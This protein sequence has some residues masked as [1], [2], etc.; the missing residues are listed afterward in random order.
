ME[1]KILTHLI[2]SRPHTNEFIDQW[3]KVYAEF[4]AERCEKCVSLRGVDIS[5]MGLYVNRYTSC[6]NLMVES[7]E[8]HICNF[9]P[10]IIG[11]ELDRLTREVFENKRLGSVFMFNNFWV[12]SCFLSTNPKLCHVYKNCS[13]S[14][15]VVRSYF[16][17]SKNRGHMFF[18][19][20]DKLF[21]RDRYRREYLVFAPPSTIDRGPEN[22]LDVLIKDI[23]FTSVETSTFL[24]YIYRFMKTVNLA[25]RNIDHISNKYI[26]NTPHLYMVLLRSLQISLETIFQNVND[27]D[28]RVRSSEEIITKF[29]NYA[30]KAN[31]LN[32]MSRR[33]NVKYETGEVM[34]L[35]LKNQ[36]KFK[37]FNHTQM[38][39][40]KNSEFTEFKSS[41]YYF[42]AIDV[43]HDMTNV[44]QQFY[45]GKIHDDSEFD[46]EIVKR[47]KIVNLNAVKCL[48]MPLDFIRFFSFFNVG[49]ISSAGRFMNRTCISRETF[50]VNIQR[51]V[52]QLVKTLLEHYRDQRIAD[53]ENLTVIYINE[54][55]IYF[56]QLEDPIHFFLLVKILVPRA[57]MTFGEFTEKNERYINI[58]I[59]NGIPLIPLTV[60]YKD[61]NAQISPDIAVFCKKC[62]TYRIR[63]SLNYLASRVNTS[64]L[65]DNNFCLR[66]ILI[67]SDELEFLFPTDKPNPYFYE[68]A[69]HGALTITNDHR[70]TEISKMMV[71]INAYKRKIQLINILE[72]PRDAFEQARN[73][74]RNLK[75]T[76]LAFEKNKLQNGCVK[77]FYTFGDYNFL[78]CEDGYVY[79][80][81]YAPNC[82]TFF[83]KKLIYECTKGSNLYF[84]NIFSLHYLDGYGVRIYIGVIYSYDPI[85]FRQNGNYNFFVEEQIEFSRKNAIRLY[86]MYFQWT[87]SF[88]NTELS[89]TVFLPRLTERRFRD[90]SGIKSIS[91]GGVFDFSNSQEH[92]DF[93][94]EYKI[95]YERTQPI[96][97]IS[98]QI[99]KQYFQI[100]IETNSVRQTLKIQ[101]S[102][103]QKGLAQYEDLSR[104]TSEHG[105]PVH[106]ITSIYS[107]LGRSAFGQFRRFSRNAVK[108]FDKLTGEFVGYGAY[109]YFFF[110]NDSAHNNFI[111]N[112]KRGGD[113]PM[114]L[115]RLTYESFLENDMSSAAYV[116]ASEFEPSNSNPY[117]GVSRGI[118]GALNCYALYGKSVTFQRSHGL[119]Y[120]RKHALDKRILQYLENNVQCK[121][122]RKI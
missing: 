74:D 16:Y 1:N 96:N 23:T 42:R 6:V 57:I 31:L 80:K 5:S 34:K 40:P 82:F 45:C 25:E 102:Y 86:F 120:L 50:F 118:I 81:T 64:D 117:S 99:S 17:D 46:F 72:N 119:T 15:S 9:L 10:I 18:L 101:N 70:F 106:L 100:L 36:I 19:H 30:H 48:M 115:C 121:R 77:L 7:N 12:F 85:Y 78:N 90:S 51:T 83:S 20:K 4:K 109:D 27:H 88:L 68:I 67:S 53:S 112:V 66:H 61:D 113:N 92:E 76:I 59:L 65:P 43:I 3:N 52:E 93:I 55:P 37:N 35:Q 28:L 39:S 91:D 8:V 73:I 107:I 84:R 62:Q 54:I 103:G 110:S 87:T 89:S 95:S 63:S 14:E 33:T 58:S 94:F 108:I 44:R 24:L 56:F 98:F 111:F 69:C 38:Y 104:Y 97:A 32:F 75:Y 21:L 41:K 29:T 122:K 22:Y 116:K 105:A 26:A 13:D 11:S 114:R 79:N 2:E 47:M 71:A 49:S 60:T